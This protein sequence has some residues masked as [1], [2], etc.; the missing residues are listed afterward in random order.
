MGQVC[1]LTLLFCKKLPIIFISSSTNSHSDKSN[2]DE[3]PFR[4]IN[5]SMTLLYESL[6][7]EVSSGSSSSCS[8]FAGNET[9]T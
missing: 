7:S 8:S 5:V 9:V 1:L 4:E 3:S 2:V 6:S